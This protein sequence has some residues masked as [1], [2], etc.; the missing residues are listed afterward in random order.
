MAPLAALLPS[1]AVSAPRARVRA[2]ELGPRS[3]YVACAGLE[4]HVTE[5][6]PAEAPVLVAWHGLARTGRDMD[7]IAAAAKELS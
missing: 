5:W 4:V 3:R 2:D 1:Q 6:G 7:D